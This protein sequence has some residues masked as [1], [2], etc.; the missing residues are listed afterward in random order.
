MNKTTRM[1]RARLCRI[2][3][4]TYALHPLLG[5]RHHECRHN[6]AHASLFRLAIPAV[7]HGSL[8]CSARSYVTR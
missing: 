7:I 6:T 2:C 1:T 5:R 8:K 4:A 3:G